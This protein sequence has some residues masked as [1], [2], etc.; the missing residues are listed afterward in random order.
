MKIDAILIYISEIIWSDWLI[1]TFLAIGVFFT[2]I[3]GFIQIRKFPTAVKEVFLKKETNEETSNLDGDITS[4]Q[5]LFIALSSCIGNGNIV[6]V[7]TSLM[8]GGP[9][10]IFWMWVASILGCATKYAEIV[11]GMVYRE[12]NENDKY[13]G[14]PLYYI[15]NGLGSKFL[16]S[17]FAILL[18]IQSSGGN[19]IQSNALANSAK[20]LFKL[21]NSLSAIILS[22]AIGVII[23]GGINTLSKMAEKLVPL[24]SFLYLTGGLAIIILNFTSLKYA[25]SLI[26]SAA[27]TPQ[28]GVGGFVG[29]SVKS[30]MKYGI[31]RG[32]YSNEA[33]EGSAPAIHASAKVDFP[34]RQG[35]YGIMEV[36]IDTLVCTITALSIL[37][38]GVVSIGYPPETLTIQAFST[39][40]PI[41]KYVV[42]ICMILFAYTSIP[43]QWHL[44]NMALEYLIGVKKSNIYKYLFI[45]FSFIGCVSTTDNLWALMDIIL[46]IMIIPNLISIVYLSPVVVKETRIFFNITSK[47]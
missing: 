44:G 1:F 41:F 36:S 13:V 29:Y 40:H 47:R 31:S 5:A 23:I 34:A 42:G 46:G 33:G 7:A 9:G 6:G 43:V 21:P 39:I 10:A 24:M 35:L 22:L 14:G 8:A 25:F 3:T 4:L 30:A 37:L 2:L 15:S 12:K 26:L 16:A 27:F 11:I 38:T 20:E 45:A 19:L 17:L 32:L 18:V 28:A